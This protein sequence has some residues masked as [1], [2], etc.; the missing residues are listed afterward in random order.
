MTWNWMARI[1]SKRVR[2][3][4]KL[5]WEDE[6]YIKH[7]HKREK[8]FL[9]REMALTSQIANINMKHIMEHHPETLPKWDK[10]N[11]GDLVWRE[12][13]LKTVKELLGKS[14][15]SITTTDKIMSEFNSIPAVES[16]G[17]FNE[18]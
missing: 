7:L 5:W 10:S 9:T 14:K 8:E 18:E 13:V 1:V 17:V 15:V 4:E 2:E 16:H 12:D 3:L 6:V 11:K